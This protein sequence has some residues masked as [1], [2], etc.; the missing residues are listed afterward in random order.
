VAIGANIF[1]QLIDDLDGFYDKSDVKKCLSKITRVSY[2]ESVNIFGSFSVSALSSGYCIGGANWII[3][4]EFDKICFIG[5]SSS[6]NPEKMNKNGLT[7]CNLVI[8]GEVNDVKEP[9][10]LEGMFSDVCKEIGKTITEGGDVLIPCYDYGVLYDIMEYIKLYLESINIYSTNLYWV[11]KNAKHATSYSYIIPEWL[12]ESKQ[13]NLIDKG[14][15][16]FNTKKMIENGTL[17]IFEKVDFNF[18]K[19]YSQNRSNPCI[20][21]CGHPSLCFGD[22]NHLIKIFEKS[23][24][25]KMILIEKTSYDILDSVVL[26]NLKLKYMHLNLN[27]TTNDANNLISFMKPLNVVSKNGVIKNSTSIQYM[28]S[29]TVA[30]NKKY[31]Y[32]LMDETFTKNLY[33]IKMKDINIS[34]FSGDLYIHD[35]EFY[36]KKEDED[37]KFN[38]KYL[39][40]QLTIKNLLI[41]LEKN[42]YEEYVISKTEY[43]VYSIFVSKLNSTILFSSNETTICCDNVDNLKI[44]K[45]IFVNNFIVI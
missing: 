40:G 32:S 8:V 26:K 24:K 21:F 15:L 13:S 38:Q 10:S 27:L 36:I 19:I 42:G 25:N 33:P 3:E 11:S 34:K 43:N 44:L 6:R 35:N 31:E 22:I 37:V 20:T 41:S 18:A 14:E 4:D 30:L 1:T 16:P 17:Q 5:N 45:K 7:K 29:V 9:Q 28:N 39:F 2:D 23:D 12:C